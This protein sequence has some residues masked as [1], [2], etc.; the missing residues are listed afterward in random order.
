[1]TPVPAN[2]KINFTALY[3]GAHRVCYRIGD[4]GSYSCITTTCTIGACIG[5]IPI[6]V[7]NETC[8]EISYEGYV[9]AECQDIDSEIDRVPWALTFTPS[10]GCKSYTVTCVNT[11]VASATI[12]NAGTEYN[13]AIPPDV[14]ITGGGGSG[15]VATATVGDGKLNI[16]AVDSFTPGSGY[17]NGTYNSVDV[18]GGSGTGAVA[19]VV[20][21]GGIVISVS[22]NTSNRGHGYQT[23]DTL[24]LDAADMGGAAPSVPATFHAVSDY[25]TVIAV[26]IT[27][28]GSAYTSVPIITIAA[29]S[30]TQAAATA[31]M[32]GC[33]A[34]TADGCSGSSV[35]IPSAAI[36]LGDSF[37]VCNTGGPPEPGTQYT[38]VQDGNCLCNCNSYT[39]GVTGPV[40]TQVRY[41]YNKCGLEVRSGLLTVGGSPSSIIDCMVTDSIKFEILTPG[42]TGTI[43]ANGDC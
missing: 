11:T 26:N 27:S 36:E 16:G 8:D 13:P 30:G 5:T 17:I 15:A 2:L 9:Q 4:S 22:I 21:L 7:D 18:T 10:P 32:S 1:M 35:V 31:V 39:I 41:F 20:V 37:S 33:T 25:G 3:N 42:T 14:L 28:S 40:S 34:I 38:V 23:T 6:F 29:S 43:T 12:T 24:G 19:T